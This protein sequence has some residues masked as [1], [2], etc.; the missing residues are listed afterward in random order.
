MAIALSVAVWAVLIALPAVLSEW[1]LS[2]LAQ[3]MSY[4]IFA[5]SLSFV[6]GQAGLL[7]FGQAI[8]FG[9]GAYAMA[10]ITKG[11]IPGLGAGTLIGLA[12]ATLLPGVIA[13]VAGWLMFRGRGLSGAYFAIVTLAAAVIAERARQ[14]LEIH[15]RLQRAARRATAALWVCCSAC[16]PA[17]NRAGVLRDAG[18]GCAWCTRSCFG[19]SARRWARRCGP[20]ATT[21][22]ALHTSAST[23][24][25]TRPPAWR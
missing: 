21:S 16:G 1:R 10:L 15:R 17:R 20:C 2:Q 12:A 4:G 19:W 25:C 9:V 3:L 23:C 8:F 5:M 22:S 6:W 7:C 13:A 14:P 18:C 24:P 11:M